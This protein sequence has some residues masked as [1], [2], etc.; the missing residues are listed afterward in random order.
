[1]GRLANHPDL[2]LMVRPELVVR[3]ST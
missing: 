2:P 1:L 3:H